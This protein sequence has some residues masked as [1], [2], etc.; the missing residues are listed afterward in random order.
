MYSTTFATTTIMCTFATML[1][2]LYAKNTEIPTLPAMDNAPPDWTDARYSHT[3]WSEKLVNDISAAND[4]Y[5]LLRNLTAEEIREVY[6]LFEEHHN[7]RRRAVRPSSAIYQLAKVLTD[8]AT[9]AADDVMTMIIVHV[10]MY[11]YKKRNTPRCYEDN[12]CFYYEYRLGLDLGAPD[13]PEEVGTVISLYGSEF[14]YSI[15]VD[16]GV[17]I[18]KYIVNWQI[19]LQ[20]PLCAIIHGFNFNDDIK[21]MEDMRDALMKTVNCNVLIVTWLNGAR[22][23][24]YTRAASNAAMVG[25]LLSLLLQAMIS[26][27]NGRL[28][29]ENIHVI[30]FSLG[31]QA[32]GFCGRHFYNN[33][34]EKIG[35]ITGLDPAGP[36]F[37]G[38]DVAL[39]SSDAQF[40][41]VI[42]TN[43]GGISQYKFGMVGKAGHV[44]FYP[45]GGES[46]PGCKNDVDLGCS[47]SRAIHL[48]IESLTSD[49]PFAAF[50]CGSDWTHLV[51][52]GEEADWWCSQKMGY[53]S[54]NQQG[55]GQFY[56]RTNEKKPYCIRSTITFIQ[57]S[58]K[59]ERLPVPLR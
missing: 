22:I 51:G 8:M 59:K 34:R 29:A 32:A 4:I 39:S 44:D 28:S 50:P 19:D 46:Q 21:W 43:A 6:E 33:T 41:D 14:N 37:E 23:P 12:G 52:R 36:L 48:F 45:N 10:L 30:G 56:L 38:T 35:R 5:W 58:S 18:P 24:D 17:W 3:G 47:H 27:S 57:D 9:K 26:T 7:R 13:K 40:V 2:G 42:H 11:L 54:I 20:K 16:K 31:G 49:C 53:N 1:G 15:K 55:R 25:A